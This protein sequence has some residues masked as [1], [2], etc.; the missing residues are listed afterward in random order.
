MMTVPGLANLHN[1]CYFNVV[2]QVGA[3]WVAKGERGRGP[4][5]QGTGPKTP[6]PSRAS[7]CTLS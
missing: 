2:L 3:V 6:G 1:T 7:M 5:G 4:G